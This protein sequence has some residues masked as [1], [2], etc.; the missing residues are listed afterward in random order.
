MILCVMVME[1]FVHL[2]PNTCTAMIQLTLLYSDY[3][4]TVLQK[5]WVLSLTINNPCFFGQGILNLSCN[6]LVSFSFFSSK[7][8]EKTT[9]FM[10]VQNAS[11]NTG[12]PPPNIVLSNLHSQYG[13]SCFSFFSLVLI[14]V[15]CLNL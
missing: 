14:P 1:N 5:A 8:T 6:N 15:L 7:D 2:S 12:F 11:L 4:I 13:T 9:V 10:T 3:S